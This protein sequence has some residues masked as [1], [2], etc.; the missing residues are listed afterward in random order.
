[1]KRGIL[2]FLIFISLFMAE[3]STPQQNET[4]ETI[5]FEKASLPKKKNDYVSPPRT[6][7]VAET[8]DMSQTDAEL[9]MKVAMAE[10]GNQGEDGQWLIMSVIL[11]R[12]E[13]E[14]FPNTIKEVVYQDHQFST[15]TNG[16]INK[17]EPT[18]ETH[19]ALARIESGQI[20]PQIIGF[21]TTDS[22]SLDKY[23]CEA[24][25]YRDHKFY[26]LNK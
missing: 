3:K 24:F 25:A 1:M 10:G 9:L 11:N 20:A 6:H 13:S 18:T 7:E 2:Y 14:E 23:F 15:V 26:T 16:S 12:V 21:E 4:V 8:V 22:Q 5:H 17:A 19:Y